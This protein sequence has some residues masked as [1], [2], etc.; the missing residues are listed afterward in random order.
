MKIKTLSKY[1][2]N[3]VLVVGYC[4]V[5][6]SL[7]FIIN[8]KS[9]APEHQLAAPNHH[10]VHWSYGGSR[11]PTRWGELSEDYIL[12]ETGKSQSPIDLPQEIPAD[13]TAQP[14]NFNYQRI[15]LTIKNNG[16]TIQVNYA[17]GS[18]IQIN[19][20]TYQLLQFHF[21]T[22]S[23]H[24]VDEKAYGME[25]HL[26]HQNH[27]GNF[28]VV[29]VLIEEG[30]ENYFL[31]PLWDHFLESEGEKKLE[32][33]MINAQSLLPE[34]REYYRYDGSLTTPPC[35]EGVNWYVMKTPIEASAEQ[36][37]QFMKIYQMN[38]RPVQPLNRRK[39]HRN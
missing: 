10:L 27:A 8:P 34:K 18:S 7:E 19:G 37:E 3:F 14:I 36:I 9:N 5:I 22:P 33:L 12:C 21:H 13:E 17:P 29:G 28:A 16:H 31:Q 25:M 35:S 11:N 32:K 6:L 26:V 24:T 30:E 23:E 38:A 4:L 2:L 39:I 15:P 1:W 20:E